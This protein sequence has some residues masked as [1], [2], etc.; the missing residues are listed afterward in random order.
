[1]FQ[2]RE[3][4]R[5]TTERELH[6]ANVLEQAGHFA[7]AIITDPFVPLFQPSGVGF[8]VGRLELIVAA[9]ADLK[10]RRSTG[11]IDD[12]GDDVDLEVTRV[13]KSDA[14]VAKPSLIFVGARAVERLFE[15]ENVV[16]CIP[17]WDMLDNNQNVCI[18]D[19][20][21]RRLDDGLMCPGALSAV[22]CDRR[23]PGA[24]SDESLNG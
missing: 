3:Q 1:L 5:L 15:L 24:G 13:F 19:A 12:A 11:A 7:K 20:V 22:S 10:I 21:T 14:A 17:A 18:E 16:L 4:D 8:R 23:L 6:V 2:R 9:I